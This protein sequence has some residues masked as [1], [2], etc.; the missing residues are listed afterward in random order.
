[1]PRERLERQKNISQYEVPQM[2]HPI[3]HIARCSRGYRPMR[4]QLS[5]KMR[6]RI[7]IN[8]S[9]NERISLVKKSDRQRG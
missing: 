4:A 5:M 6:A 7:S 8:T 2:F 9:A 3:P 1:L